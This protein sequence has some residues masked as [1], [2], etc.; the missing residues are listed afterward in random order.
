[1]ILFTFFVHV[2]HGIFFHVF[3]TLHRIKMFKKNMGIQSRVVK[4]SHPKMT[5]SPGW[6]QGFGP[7]ENPEKKRWVFLVDFYQ[8]IKT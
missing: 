6:T 1:M 7:M 8:Q 3:D 5:S 4:S 2:I